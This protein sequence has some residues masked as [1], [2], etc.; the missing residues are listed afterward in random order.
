MLQSKQLPYHQEKEKEEYL[1]VLYSGFTTKKRKYVNNN[2]KNHK[3]CQ[4]NQYVNNNSSY[5]TCDDKK[6]KKKRKDWRCKT[7]AL[8]NIET[9]EY[10]LKLLPNG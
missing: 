7:I 6:R 9:P 10:P 4:K 3:I 5:R 1:N 2:I 8:C